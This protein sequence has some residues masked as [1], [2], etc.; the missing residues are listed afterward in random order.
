MYIYK[1][2]I[3]IH[4]SGINIYISYMG[5][6]IYIYIE[7]YYIIIYLKLR[8]YICLY[9]YFQYTKIQYNKKYSN[10]IVIWSNMS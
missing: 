4:G 7:W 5:W 10:I 9:I 1:R 3:Y 6:Y 8:K 2:G